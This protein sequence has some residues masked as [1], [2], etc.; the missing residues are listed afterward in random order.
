VLKFT[1]PA[2]YSCDLKI[3][4]N[5]LKQLKENFYDPKEDDEPYR[6]SNPPLGRVWRAVV[7][8]FF[9]SFIFV[10]YATGKSEQFQG[11]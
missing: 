5:R 6:R 3:G 10:F 8:E 7:A 1:E 4:M 11:N 2:T 9:A